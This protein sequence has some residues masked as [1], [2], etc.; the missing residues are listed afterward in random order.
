M[1]RG[2]VGEH[3]N[4][5]KGSENDNGPMGGMTFQQNINFTGGVDLA[6]RDEVAR[7]AAATKQQTLKAISEANRRR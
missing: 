6:T 7:M 2:T 1:F 3:V 5:T 4:V